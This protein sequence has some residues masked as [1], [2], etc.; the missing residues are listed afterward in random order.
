MRSFD[1]TMVV[2]EETFEGF[3]SL[4]E[5][6]EAWTLVDPGGVGTVHLCDDPVS[7]GGQGR[8]VAVALSG[9]TSSLALRSVAT[10]ATGTYTPQ[11]ATTEVGFDYAI[12]YRADFSHLSTY[13]RT[14]RP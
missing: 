1:E 5:R 4:D 12:R 11:E 9:A 2:F 10:R 3:A 14:S 13:V 8:H 6:A 7:A